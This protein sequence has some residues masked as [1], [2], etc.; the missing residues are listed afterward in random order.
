MPRQPKNSRILYFL[1]GLYILASMT[2]FVANISGFLDDYFDV[3]HRVTTPLTFDI[4][5]LKIA[6]LRPEAQKTGLAKGDALVSVNGK[7]YA[8]NAQWLT[9]IR[10]QLHP[11]D[12]LQ[13]VVR[14]PDGTIQNADFILTGRG[15][16]DPPIIHEWA[17]LL[18]FF[19]LPPLVCLLIGY[20]VFAARPRDLNAWMILLI[21]TFPETFLAIDSGWWPGYWN[22]YSQV[23]T[24]VVQAVAPLALLLFGIYFPERWRLDRKAPWLKWLLIAPGVVCTASS[25]WIIV[26]EEYFPVRNLAL[27]SL[28]HWTNLIV[29][30]IDTAC[31]F[32]YWVAIFDKSRSASTADARRRLHVL[33]MGSLIGLGSVL[34]FVMAPLFHID[35]T[36]RWIGFTT[37]IIF[38]V[39]P[40]TLAYVVVVQ[41]AMDVR[42][43]LRMGTKYALARATLTVVRTGLLIVLAILLVRLVRAPS[44]TPRTMIEIAILAALLG[45]LRSRATRNLSSWLDRKFFREAYNAEQLLAEL[46]QRVRKYTDTGPM[47]EMVTRSLVQTLHIDKIAVLLRGGNAFQLQQAV[48]LNLDGFPGGQPVQLPLNSTTARNLMRINTPVTLYRENP[49]GWLLLASESERRLLDAMSTELL[50]P[51]SGRDQLMGLIT[52]GPKRSEE[53]YTSS[54]LRLLESVATQTGLALEIGNLARSL[55]KEAT[56]RERI[57]REIEV[58]RE[59]QERLFPQE[60]PVIEGVSLAGHCRPAQ[61]V[62]G[63]YYDLFTLGDGRIGIAIGD[64]SGKGISA[65]LLMASLRASLRGM[66]LDDPHDLAV[67]M[68]RVNRLVYEASASNR[69]AT[70]FF[71]TYN[72]ATRELVY[73]NAGHNAPFLVRGVADTFRVQRLEAGGPVVGLLSFATYEEQRLLLAPGDLLLTYTDGIS[74]AMTLD[75]EEWGEERMLAAAQTLPD[76]TAQEVLEHLFA[77][78]DRFTGKAPQHDDMTLLVLKLARA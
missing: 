1:L 61:G 42:I 30:A 58:A 38:L 24:Q 36:Q 68:E 64:V 26:D 78:A 32:L 63:D 23:W 54:D 56:Q 44:L 7:A 59:V 70:F 2:Y 74:E 6:S 10:S 77:E 45:L 37:A 12:R 49:D 14:K 27:H 40:F 71:A 18:L 35:N 25:L 62:G 31:I 16:N 52:L 41:R 75:D 22:L 51:L 19:G 55:A 72:I 69:Y 15:K 3:H 47:L 4:D 67:T 53:P 43:L 21:L 17:G 46:S 33:G 39:F 29:F 8:G 76:G 34:L 60:F 11:G 66:T 13:L 57:D 28:N 50:L 5:T 73:V 48:G 20:W 65:A 9:L